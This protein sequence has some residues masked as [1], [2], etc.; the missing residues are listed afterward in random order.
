MR[1]VHETEAL[2][3][4]DPVPKHHSS[5]PQN[6][7]QRVKLTFKGLGEKAAAGAANGNGSIEPV[8]KPEA[9]KSNTSAPASPL[10]GPTVGPTGDVDYEHNN[11]IYLPAPI[12]SSQEFT[13]HFPPDINFTDEEL[14]LPP[15]QLLRVL[16]SQLQWAIQDGDELRKEV[17]ELDARRKR[18]WTAKELVLENNM[19]AELSRDER[20]QT[21]RGTVLGPEDQHMLRA[22]REDAAPSLAL[23]ITGGEKLPWWRESGAFAPRREAD[24]D[25]QMEEMGRPVGE[26]VVKMEGGLHV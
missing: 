3:P 17:N 12:G 2:R 21:I 14:S 11:I 5:N 18:E 16:K 7:S 15:A 19:E 13:P 6:K 20:K 4:S 25:V 9:P 26:P 22:M 23:D 24:G 8:T 10:T 1:T